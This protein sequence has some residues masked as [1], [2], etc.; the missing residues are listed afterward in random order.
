MNTPNEN[1]LIDILKE[2]DGL[3]N[4]PQGIPV[5]ITTCTIPL[6]QQC[7][8]N[9]GLEEHTCPYEEIH[10]CQDKCNCCDSCERDCAWSI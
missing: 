6:C 2:L 5:R 10:N 8:K 7:K 9:P 3:P 4:N 1:K